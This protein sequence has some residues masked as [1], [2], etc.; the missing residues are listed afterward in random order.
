M[1]K[2]EKTDV[3]YLPPFG[4]V[5]RLVF[6]SALGVF[7]QPFKTL[8]KQFSLPFH[9]LQPPQ[10]CTPLGHSLPVQLITGSTPCSYPWYRRFLLTSV[11]GKLAEAK[12]CRRTQATTGNQA[13]K[14]PRVPHPQLHV[15]H[16]FET[17][18]S[19]YRKKKIISK[20]QL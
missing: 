11:M 12:P 4:L 5:L 19:N 14:A 10:K 20:A 13:R 17:T 9:I 16:S 8:K 7:C 6:S 2:P 3:S 1:Q 18:R 15:L